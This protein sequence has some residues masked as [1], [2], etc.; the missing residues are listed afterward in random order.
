[1]A[2]RVAALAVCAVPLAL[3]AIAADKVDSI[4]GYIDGALKSNHYSG[5]LPV[6]NSSGAGFGHLHYWLIEA[7]TRP[8]TAPLVMWLNGGPGAS[9]LIGLLN[10]NGQIK[11][12][13][14]SR[15]MFDDPEFNDPPSFYNEFSWSQIANFLYLEQPKGVGYS[16]CDAGPSNCSNT[17]DNIGP[18]VHD[19]LVAFFQGFSEYADRDF[20]IAGESYAGTYIPLI[21]KEIDDRG[22]IT[23]LVGAAIGN[24]C[25]SGT[26]FND[27]SEDY[28]DFKTMAGHSMISLQLEDEITAACGDWSAGA[29]SDACS[30]LVD[31]MRAE[32]EKHAVKV[33]AGCRLV[34][35]VGRGPIGCSR[36][37]AGCSRHA[38]RAWI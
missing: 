1:M 5:Y 19:F 11:V 36:H 20:W 3:G 24:G 28:M 7:E 31:K 32:E 37:A 27:M 10:E 8:S 38:T 13:G 22:E 33:P 16:Y 2:A 21:M 23:N 29:T 12:N 34:G 9:S 26:C 25:T 4:P 18:D 15:V 30:D 17:D 14:N 35:E 6:G